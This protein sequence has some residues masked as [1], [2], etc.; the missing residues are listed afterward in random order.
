[1]APFDSLLPFSLFFWEESEGIVSFSVNKALLSAGVP[2]EIE[3]VSGMVSLI[4]CPFAQIINMQNIKAKN[5]RNN[6]NNLPFITC[7][8][9]P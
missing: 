1:M 7:W 4:V 3:S 5:V 9:N 6:T 8:S 2:I